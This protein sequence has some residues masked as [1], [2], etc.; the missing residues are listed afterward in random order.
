MAW[1]RNT[2]IVF[3]LLTLYGCP[4]QVPATSRFGSSDSMAGADLGNLDDGAADTG[5]AVDVATPADL[6]G[7]AADAPSLDA[8][9]PDAASADAGCAKNGCPAPSACHSATCG[10][11]GQCSESAV[12]DGQ[13]CGGTKT[14]HGGI[15]LAEPPKAERVVAAG[16]M[17][18]ILLTTGTLKCWG[19]DTLGQ[20]GDGQSGSGAM[21][22]TPVAVQS[23]STVTDLA[24]GGDHCCAI[25]QD[26]LWCWGSNAYKQSDPS[27]GTAPVLVPTIV[28]GIAQNGLPTS[29]AAGTNHSCTILA[30]KVSCWGLGAAGQLGTGASP[31]VGAIA[32]ASLTDYALKVSA[33]PNFTCARTAYSTAYCWGDNGNGQIGNGLGGTSQFSL[34]PAKVGDFTD[35]SVVATGS[36]HACAIRSGGQ[37]WCWGHASNGE[38]GNGGGNLMYAS[39]VQAQGVSDIAT[40]AAGGSHTCAAA[41][42]GAVSC[43]GSNSNGQAGLGSSVS[44]SKTAKP[45]PGL[46]NVVEL[47]AGDAHTCARK[48]D[49][50]VWCWGANGM[51][52]CGVGGSKDLLVPVQAW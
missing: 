48:K 19:E 50:S 4:G 17:T 18:C 22:A 26:K 5:A 3:A 23:L 42:G 47:A 31:V 13:G 8:A 25:A 45:V 43:W 11:N 28:A 7:T 32:A 39:P 46:D 24:C 37:V 33:G 1:H 27:A 40:I 51:G 49:G 14:C 29:V 34:T 38:L 2:A 9:G 36:Q 44:Q 15:C 35:V 20:L 16:Q 6:G 21:S 52:Q 10:A 12:A 30:G 41:S